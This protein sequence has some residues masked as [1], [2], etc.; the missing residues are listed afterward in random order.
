MRT[1]ADYIVDELAEAQAKRGTGYVGALGRKRKD[2]SVVDGEEI[3][4]EVM[5]G[6]IKS[7]GFDLNGSWSPLYTVHK[8][9]A[10]LLD[11]HGAWGNKKALAVVEG[12]GGYFERVFAAL[13]PAQ[14]QEVLGCEYGGLN[15]SYAEMH[16]RTGNP[17]WLKMA[18]TL[19]DTRV[20]DPLS[21]REDKLANFHANTQV[22]KL[23]GLA[24]IYDITGDESGGP[25]R[26]SSG[27]ASPA[28]TAS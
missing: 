10:G 8:L 1:R 21:N 2:G 6:E 24:R 3:F 27:S 23:I 5:K 20:L 22:P 25:R 15:E 9:F 18:E 16:Q 28:I 12:L 26:L 17:R 11:V 7:G 14:V 13:T 19:Y 4:G